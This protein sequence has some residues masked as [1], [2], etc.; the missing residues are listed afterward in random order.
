VRKPG[1]FAA[2]RYRDELFPTTTFRLA[3]DRLRRDGAKRADRDYV[4]ILHL[5]ASTSE[6]EVETALQIVLE[7]GKAPT[8][9][10]VRDLVQVPGTPQ[11]PTIEVPVLDL[12]AYDQLIPSR[13][14]CV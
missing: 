10:A 9:A 13:R 12:S 11:I 8:F 4:R 5:A 2:Y 3:Y 1:A 7:A 14:N 6:A